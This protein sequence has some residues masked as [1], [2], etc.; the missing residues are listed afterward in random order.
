MRGN[1]QVIGSFCGIQPPQT[2]YSSGGSLRVEFKNTFRA[3]AK[4]FVAKY[5][6]IQ[7][8]KEVGRKR[9]YDYHLSK[10]GKILG[11]NR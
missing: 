3:A 2:I 6:A 9:I 10:R 8:G 11:Q 5:T 1:S 4:G 7:P